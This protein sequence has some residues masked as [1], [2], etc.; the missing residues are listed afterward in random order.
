MNIRK[1]FVI[2]SILLGIV[3][4]LI[5]T[6]IC[7]TNLKNRNIEIIK[8]NLITAAND[9][10]THLEAFFE[11]NV[12]NLNIIADMPITK[13]L[14]IDSNNKVNSTN[15]QYDREIVDQLLNGQKNGEFFL[16]RISLINKD[17]VITASS[18]EV[19]IDKDTVLSTIDMEKL[20]NNKMLV[21]DVIER[22]DFNN[23][24]K[25]VIIASP[26]FFNNEYQGAMLSVVDMSYFER[27]VDDIMFFKSGKVAI[28]DNDGTVVASSS[29][30]VKYNINRI[31]SPNNLYTQWKT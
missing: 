9:Q 21:T 5:A 20:I 26:I 15:I 8:Q 12:S 18:D 24:V 22:K 11:Q 10:S 28:M 29:E 27:L 17:G 7:I 19:Y 4:T 25:S 1:R 6:S 23:G 2:F 13:E 30:Q 14:L 16:S 31:D 3:P